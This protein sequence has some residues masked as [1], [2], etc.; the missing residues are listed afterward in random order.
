MQCS[1]RPQCNTFRCLYHKD[2]GLTTYTC[3]QTCT[4]HENTVLSDLSQSL[5]LSLL[6]LPPHPCLG[7]LLQHHQICT[8]IHPDKVVDGLS[9]VAL[10]G[11]GSPRGQDEGILDSPVDLQHSLKE[12]SVVDLWERLEQRQQVNRCGFDFC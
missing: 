7:G 8:V 10:F 6:Q 4:G 9:V 12:D 3:R 11:V 1:V 5:L 2:T